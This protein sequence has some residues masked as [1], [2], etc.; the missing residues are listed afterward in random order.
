[1]ST[2][3]VQMTDTRGAGLCDARTVSDWYSHLV[4]E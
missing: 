2:I 4:H 1:M 3:T